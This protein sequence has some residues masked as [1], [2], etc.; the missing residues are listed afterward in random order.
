MDNVKS[1]TLY[2]DSDIKSVKNDYRLGSLNAPKGSRIV[3]TQDSR[4]QNAINADKE[5]TD[6]IIKGTI[7]GSDA[8]LSEEPYY[9]Q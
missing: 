3:N 2:F 9:A 6:N 7:Y 4:Y 5:T 8:I 1:R